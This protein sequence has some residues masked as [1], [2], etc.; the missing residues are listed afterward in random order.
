MT[1]KS[2]G[3]LCNVCIRRGSRDWMRQRVQRLTYCSE[4]D[5]GAA[6][7]PPITDE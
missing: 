1:E 2:S 3:E 6:A 4:T 7:Q 5:I